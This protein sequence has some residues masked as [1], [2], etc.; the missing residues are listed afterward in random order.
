MEINEA[1]NI[2]KTT[3]NSL[4][5]NNEVSWKTILTE[6]IDTVITELNKLE[7]KLNYKNKRL[8]KTIKR[9]VGGKL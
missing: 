5:N 1:K 9:K 3:R 8:H 4:E 6:A 7:S 2:L